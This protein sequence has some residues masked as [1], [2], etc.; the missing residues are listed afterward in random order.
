MVKNKNILLFGA[1]GSLG[2]IVGEKL[3]KFNNVVKVLNTN[4]RIFLK[5]SYEDIIYCNLEKKINTN[6]LPI[7]FDIIIYLAQSNLDLN[8]VENCTKVF[9]VNA[10]NPYELAHWGARNNV[11][12]FIYCSTGGVYDRSINLINENQKINIFHKDT[13]VS[14]KISAELMLNCLKN[15]LSINILRPF[16]ILGNYKNNIRLFPRLLDKIVNKENIILDSDDGILINPI[17]VDNAADCVINSISLNESNTINIAGKE[18]VSLREIIEIFG[19]EVSIKP[20]IVVNK[21]NN[22]NLVADISKME[23]LLNPKFSNIKKCLTNFVKNN[24]K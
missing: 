1:T 22:K 9:N 14:S 18:I 7:N 24:L 20:K 3:N 2:S 11:N 19:K 12:T 10:L 8:K 6:K 21:I 13:Y 16:F 23:N 4:K 17:A 15:Q 5:N